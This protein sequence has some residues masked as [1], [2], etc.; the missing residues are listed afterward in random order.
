M[1]RALRIDIR[2]GWYHITNRGLDRQRIFEDTRDYGHFLELLGEMHERYL[3]RV[4]AYVL[5]ANHY[6]LLIQTPEANASQAMQWLNMSYSLWFN[7]RHNRVGPLFQ[8]RFQSVLIEGDGAWVLEACFYLHLNPVCTRALGLDKRGRKVEGRGLRSPN[9]EQTRARMERLRSYRWSSYRAYAG[10][11][12]KAEWL[13]TG[14]VLRRSGGRER[15]RKRIE[16]Y[17][18]QEM[19]EDKI[20]ALKARLLLGSTAFVEAMK[21]RISKMSKE[22]PDRKI[23]ERH[24]TFNQ[25][26]SV[27][28]KEIGEK[29]NRFFN[30]HGDKGRDMVLYLARKRSGLTLREIGE[31]AGGL[32]Y[33]TVGKAIERFGRWIKTDSNLT[34]SLVKCLRQLSNVET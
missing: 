28:E 25:I 3:V 30:R 14:E 19:N 27:V 11:C 15:L 33:K 31:C 12:Q 1:A 22:Q 20:M 26:V 13:E 10:Y 5:M 8:G 4:H 24:V 2:D 18:M 32:E 17:L 7:C 16:N 23:L 21:Q 29:W 34:K 6:H 9:A